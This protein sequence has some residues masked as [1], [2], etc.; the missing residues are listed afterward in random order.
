MIPIHAHA[1]RLAVGI[2]LCCSGERAVVLIIHPSRK[3]KKKKKTLGTHALCKHSVSGVP[4]SQE[5]RLLAVGMDQAKPHL[6]LWFAPRLP[7]P[8]I[9]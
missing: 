1:H 7:S 5:L 8:V 9:S 2:A 3:W 6:R 4:A